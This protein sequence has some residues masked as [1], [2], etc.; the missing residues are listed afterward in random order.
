[1]VIGAAKDDIH[2]Q[3]DGPM[4]AQTAILKKDITPEGG[5]YEVVRRA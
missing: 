3:G 5:D 1:M 2:D 4:N